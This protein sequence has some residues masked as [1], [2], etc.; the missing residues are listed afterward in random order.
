MKGACD[1]FGGQE[2]DVPLAVPT[3]GGL[4]NFL[5]ETEIHGEVGVHFNHVLF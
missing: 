4:E 1:E 3:K 5:G 2:G